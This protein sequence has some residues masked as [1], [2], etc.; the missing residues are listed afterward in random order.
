[1]SDSGD[2]RPWWCWVGAG[3]ELCPLPLWLLEGDGKH[4]S[5]SVL[6]EPG[7][8]NWRFLIHSP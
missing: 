5:G 7:P 8:P 6:I 4:S 3:P 2:A 1:M